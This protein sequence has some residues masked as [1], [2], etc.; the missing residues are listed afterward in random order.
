MLDGETD[1]VEAEEQERL[2]AVG[3]GEDVDLQRFE[4]AEAG[5]EAEAEAAE[6][7]AG[8]WG[9]VAAGEADLELAGHGDGTGSTR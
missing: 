2:T 9:D 6:V 3:G 4:G 8:W 5:A 7:D 1:Q